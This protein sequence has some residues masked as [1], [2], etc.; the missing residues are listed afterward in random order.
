M[1]PNLGQPLGF[2]FGLVENH[3]IYD[4]FFKTIQNKF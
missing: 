2:T 4:Y 1:I 3:E